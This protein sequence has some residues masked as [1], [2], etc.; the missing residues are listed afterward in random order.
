MTEL[1]ATTARPYG[2]FE[3]TWDSPS[4]GAL[5]F[6]TQGPLTV[7]GTEVALD[8]YP[9]YENPWTTVPFDADDLSIAAG[10]FSLGL[11]FATWTRSADAAPLE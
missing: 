5:D 7:D 8:G 4:Q 3:V 2:E 9:R 1:P 6:G 10:R 11:D